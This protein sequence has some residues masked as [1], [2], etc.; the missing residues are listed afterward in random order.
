MSISTDLANTVCNQYNVEQVVCP[1]E[2]QKDTFTCGAVDNIDHNTSARTS[3]DSF[4][5]T[6]ISLM[7]FPTVEMRGN[8]AGM[9]RINPFVTKIMKLPHSHQ[10]TQ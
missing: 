7:Q 10:L 4:H 3:H 8:A 1:H 2:L 5:G 9:T 6:A